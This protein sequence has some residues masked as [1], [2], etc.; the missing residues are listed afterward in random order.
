MRIMKECPPHP[1][2]RGFSVLRGS[3]PRR[4]NRRV[5]DEV[6]KRESPP[7]EGV[8]RESLRLY[9]DS[10]SRVSGV[11]PRRDRKTGVRFTHVEGRSR[12]QVRPVAELVQG[13]RLPR[14]HSLGGSGTPVVSPPPW[15]GLGGVTDWRQR[16]DWVTT[17]PV[18][19]DR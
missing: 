6:R 7:Y 19:V 9:F 10:S 16:S 15:D 5:R 3:R 13:R 4:I 11:G 1:P 18:F 12:A 14:V 8:I 2:R 17:D